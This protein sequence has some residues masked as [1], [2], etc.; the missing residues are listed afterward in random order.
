MIS[1]QNFVDNC[2]NSLNGDG[3]DAEEVEAVVEADQPKHPSTAR[4][5]TDL[6]IDLIFVAPFETTE[7][8]DDHKNQ[9]MANR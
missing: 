5:A 4:V 3:E 2:K 9:S 8:R 7:F 1:D 6:Q